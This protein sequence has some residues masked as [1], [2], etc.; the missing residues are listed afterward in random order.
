MEMVTVGCNISPM[1]VAGK[2]VVMILP[3]VGIVV[4]PLFTVYLTDYVK[5][6]NNSQS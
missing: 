3:I 6:N 4:F 1:T 2:I 5:R